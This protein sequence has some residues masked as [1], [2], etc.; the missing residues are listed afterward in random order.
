M[1]I[2]KLIELLE[3]STMSV[4]FSGAG[5]STLSGIRDFR[6]EGGFYT[7]DYKGYQVEELLS[8]D[9]FLQDPSL[10]Y[11]WA[12]EFVYVLDNFTPSIVHTTLA[13]LED[14]GLIEGVYTQNIDLLH[15]KAGSKNVVE[16]HGSPATSYCIECNTKSN[17]SLDAPYVAKGEVP[18]C[19]KCGGVIKPDIIFYGEQ[20]VPQ[21]LESTFDKMGQADLVLALGSSL[22]V[23]PA[24]SMPLAT[25]QN[26]GS[27]VIVN[28]QKT[29]LDSYATV[30]LRDLEST[31]NS[32]NDYFN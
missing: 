15:Q 9:L 25:I 20:L 16:I 4:V 28:N 12:K 22:T 3:N 10:F 8:M 18:K 29:P 32:L 5:V 11:N 19:K 21:V 27:L 31:F 26:G 13:K 17:Y 30:V 7:S 24:A 2:K 6:G 23:Q 1:M 14:K